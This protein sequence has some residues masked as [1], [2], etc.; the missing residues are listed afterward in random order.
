MVYPDNELQLAGNGFLFCCTAIA[1]VVDASSSRNSCHFCGA[2]EELLNVVNGAV[3]SC[4]ILNKRKY[5]TL[6]KVDYNG[7]K[8]E[9]IGY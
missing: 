6:K 8:V 2:F 3:F 1:P 4:A 5:E 7:D 9:L